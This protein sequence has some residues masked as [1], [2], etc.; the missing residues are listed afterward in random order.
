MCIKSGGLWDTVY[1]PHSIT[2]SLTARQSHSPPAPPALRPALLAA[3]ASAMPTI[4]C[5]GMGK[6]ES[7]GEKCPLSFTLVI[8]KSKLIKAAFITKPVYLLWTSVHNTNASKVG[9]AKKAA[10]SSSDIAAALCRPTTTPF[11][12]QL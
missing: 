2:S 9:F 10:I 4:A 1:I 6:S 11:L 8:C 7:M 12:L 5:R 3:R